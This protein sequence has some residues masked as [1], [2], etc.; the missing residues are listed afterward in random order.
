MDK[1]VEWR[2]LPWAKS[3]AHFSGSLSYSGKVNGGVAL[4]ERSDDGERRPTGCQSKAQHK[5]DNG[6]GGG[7]RRLQYLCLAIAYVWN[8]C[9][10]GAG[11]SMRAHSRAMAALRFAPK[12]PMRSLVRAEDKMPFL[13]ISRAF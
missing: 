5:Q 7:G 6:G 9:A 4:G 3:K 2:E 12:S 8:G 11:F 1:S 13:E 10:T